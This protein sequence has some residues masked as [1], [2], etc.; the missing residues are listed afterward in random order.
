[1]ADTFATLVTEALANL[2]LGSESQTLCEG[3]ANRVIQDI[4]GRHDWFWSRS[5]QIVQPNADKSDGT[6]SITA[7]GNALVGTGTSFAAADVGKF[8]RLQSSYD[9]YRITAVASDVSAT[10]E[11]PYT[12]STDLTDGTYLLRQ[13]FYSV[14]NARKIL[15]AKQ[16]ITNVE[17]VCMHYKDYDTYLQFSESVAKATRFCL[18]GIDANNDLQFKIHPHAD[19]TYNIEMLVKTKATPDDLSKIPEDFRRVYLDGILTAGL[20]FIALGNP[21]QNL[22]QA[23][24]KKK[25]DYERGIARMIANAEPEADYMAVIRNPDLPIRRVNWG[26]LPGDMS[27]PLDNRNG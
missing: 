12:G 5:R 16:A 6:V 21:Q 1:M 11:A 8:I 22:S 27:I 17:L 18:Y 20:E 7:G 15:G 26:R 25:S 4:H 23:I 3:W 10:I 2:R 9:W 14:P 19:E 24:D 13:I